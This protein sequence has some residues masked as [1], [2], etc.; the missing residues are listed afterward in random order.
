LASKVDNYAKYVKEM[1]WPE[2]SKKKQQELEDMKAQ[3]L[4]RASVKDLSRSKASA[5]TGK[6]PKVGSAKE[7]SPNRSTANAS[8]KPVNW[9]KFKNPLVPTSTSHQN[10]Y[11]STGNMEVLKS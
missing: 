9:K 4:H 8:K 2:V 10:P 1:Y 6:L 3:N 5:S 11:A 7:R